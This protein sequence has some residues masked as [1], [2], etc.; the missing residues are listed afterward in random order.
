MYR[1]YPLSLNQQTHIGVPSAESGHVRMLASVSWKYQYWRRVVLMITCWKVSSAQNSEILVARAV[2]TLG[3]IVPVHLL[4]PTRKPI[5]LCSECNLNRLSR[6]NS[7]E[8]A[9]SVSTV[10][11]C[12]PLEEVLADLAKDTSLST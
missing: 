11:C 3:E 8:D 5:D 7:E 1:L 10:S 2:V 12:A 6:N 9:N 4:N